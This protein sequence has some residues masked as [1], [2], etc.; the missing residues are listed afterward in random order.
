MK[1][2]RGGIRGEMKMGGI[3]ERKGGER[4]GKKR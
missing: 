4:E 2:R 3:M 1:G